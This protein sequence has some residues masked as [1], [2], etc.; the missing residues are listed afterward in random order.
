[1][2]GFFGMLREDG[3][4]VDPRLLERV[5][6]A[7]RFRG[8]DG[9]NVW[10]SGDMGSCFALM[11]TGPA[12]QVQSQPVTLDQ[13]FYLWGDIRLDGREELYRRLAQ[14]NRRLDPGASSEEYFLQAWRQ[15]GQEALTQVIG[16]FSLALWDAAGKT[17]WCA[18]DFMGVRALYYAR[19]GSTFC[20][21]NA[22]E[23]L[24]ELP[25]VSD[26]LDEAWIAD[27]FL[28]DWNTEPSRTVFKNIRRL[29][30]GHVLQFAR[31]KLNVHRFR[32]LPVEEPLRLKRPEEYVEIYRELV[33]A[34][35]NDRLPNGPTA[36]YLSGGLDSGAVCA[37]AS[38]LAEA[39]GQKQLL[40]AFTAS[41]RPLLPDEE[42][43]CAQLTARHLCIAH[44]IFAEEEATPF[45]RTADGDGKTPEPTT[46]AFFASGQKHWR[47]VAEH[48]NVAL[49]GDGGDDILTGQAWPYL[50]HLSKSGQWKFLAKDFG[51]FLLKH[52]RIPPLRG[53]FRAKVARIFGKDNRFGEYPPWLNKDFETRTHLRYRWEQINR[54]AQPAWEHPTHPLAYRRLHSGYWSYIYETEDSGWTRVPLELRA[55]LLDLRVLQYLLRL[56]PVP[57]CVEKKLC[58]LAMQ[59]LLPEKILKRPKTPVPGDMLGAY[60]EKLWR[61]SLPADAPAALKT[62]V[63]WAKWCE[64]FQRAQGFH[65]WL[66]FRP[67][68]LLKWFESR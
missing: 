33:M 17:L 13:R 26:E 15:W 57:W 51:T 36:L 4:A 64:T 49:G 7:L 47:I 62:F 61:P 65:S 24:Q 5:A 43:E 54:D 67:L 41:A 20:F 27:F 34:A 42:P 44:E 31:G 10:S 53:G 56:P 59:G 66:D 2:S 28:D 23:V 45:E 52:G 16:E 68:S 60:E 50:V 25:E 3:A 30:G 40:K 38:Q 9:V 35:V 46:E 55:P 48:S 37:M 29:P 18:R 19:V 63:N 11:R 58:R 1:M 32:K 12:P 14:E 39:R 8:P 6:E 21:S 22:L